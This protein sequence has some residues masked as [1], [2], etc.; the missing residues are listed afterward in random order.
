[1]QDACCNKHG[2]L[3]TRI[4]QCEKDLDDLFERSRVYSSFQ[5]KTETTLEYIKASIDEL[6]IAVTKIAE[7]PNK[8]WETLTTTGISAIVGAIVAYTVTHLK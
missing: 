4:K 6:K 1:M 3:E 5:S 2:E 8:R 7:Q